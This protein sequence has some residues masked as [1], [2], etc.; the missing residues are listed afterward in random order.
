MTTDIPPPRAAIAVDAPESNIGAA[1]GVRPRA[2]G[3]RT[4]WLLVRETVRAWIDHRASSLGAALA[5]YTA[6]SLAP[7]LLIAIAV[8]G[9]WVDSDVAARAVAD[10]ASALLGPHAAEGVEFMLR[11]APARGQR[12]AGRRPGAG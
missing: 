3:V 12:M 5:Y 2:S 6:F 9:L 8:A 7:L 1:A 11:V 4:A 10:Q